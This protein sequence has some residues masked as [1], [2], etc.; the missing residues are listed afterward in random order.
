MLVL[1]GEMH[2]LDDSGESHLEPGIWG[3]LSANT[4]MQSLHG[5]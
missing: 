5:G 1:S 3:Y 4:C 2:L